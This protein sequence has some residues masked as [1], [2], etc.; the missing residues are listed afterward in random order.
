MKTIVVV[1]VEGDIEIL[2]M[3]VDLQLRSGIRLK[4]ED[5]GHQRRDRRREEEEEEEEKMVEVD[6]AVVDLD[7]KRKERLNE[8][9]LD[10]L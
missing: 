9:K 5:H 3:G 4:R 6:G 7:R 8:R 2:D 1:D 10:G